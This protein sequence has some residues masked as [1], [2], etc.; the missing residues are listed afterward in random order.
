MAADSS[1]TQMFFFIAAIVVAV[2]V[3][4]V[5]I[6]ISNSMV[7]ELKM[8]S[9][10]LRTELGTDIEIV[11]DPRKVPYTD[12]NLTIYLKN[13]GDITL[14]YNNIVILIDG[15]YVNGTSVVNEYSGGIW[16]IGKTVEMQITVSLSTGDHEIKAVMP[17]GVSD[18][19]S[20]R[21]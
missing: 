9:D 15:Q 11:N 1:F 12:G 10:T 14:K 13:V 2:S 3:S 18:T 19:M 20:F 16:P 8:K 7:N 17:N 6:G 21:I 5:I 4:G